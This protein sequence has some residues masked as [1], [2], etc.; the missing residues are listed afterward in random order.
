MIQY[1]LSGFIELLCPLLQ[2]LLLEVKELFLLLKD[3]L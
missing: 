1:L 2:F 3:G